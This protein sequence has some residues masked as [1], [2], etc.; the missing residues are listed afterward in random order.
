MRH[1]T[2]RRSGYWIWR[3]PVIPVRWGLSTGDILATVVSQFVAVLINE[4]KEEG[5]K[6]N[7][8]LIAAATNRCAR[9]PNNGYSALGQADSH[10]RALRRRRASCCLGAN[11]FAAWS[12]NHLTDLAPV[13]GAATVARLVK[14][15]LFKS[16]ALGDQQS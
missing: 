9:A 11:E 4:K 14:S 1:R 3:C 2:T 16:T 8:R 10:W 6:R 13:Q 5:K 12:F 15:T 7:D